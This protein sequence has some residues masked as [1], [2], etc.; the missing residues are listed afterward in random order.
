MIDPTLDVCVLMCGCGKSDQR[1]FVQSS[2]SIM[3]A[4]KDQ[5]DWFLVLD[6]EGKIVSE[7]DRHLR[8]DENYREWLKI[9]N[10][11]SKVRRLPMKINR[12]LK[13]A[14]DALH[15][16]TDDRKYIAVALSSCCKTVLT[17]ASKSFTKPLCKELKKRKHGRICVMNPNEFVHENPTI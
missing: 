9:L 4:I 10:H 14:L 5:E 8:M 15:F 3:N 2:E 12:K 11:R 1:R 17:F 16:N 6:I 7:Y 13:V